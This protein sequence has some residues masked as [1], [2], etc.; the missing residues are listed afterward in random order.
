MAAVREPL[1]HQPEIVDLRRVTGRQLQP[2]LL[3]ETVEWDRT[4][5]W[6]FGRSAELVVQYADSRNLGGVALLD[7]GEVAGY[8]YSVLEDHKGLIG[9]LYI[10]PP[11]RT[12]ENEA[13][14]LR[15]M[16]QALV[17]LH[18]VSRIESQIML[19]D[20]AAARLVERDHPVRLHERIL[21]TL[22]L[23]APSEPPPAPAH[24]RLEP[25][26]DLHHQYA[27]AIIASSYKDH[28]DSL[29]NDQYRSHAGAQRFLYNIVQYPGCGNFCRAAS[30]LAFDRSTGS[31]AGVVLSSLVGR[32]TGHI[33]QLCIA[34]SAQGQG[35][36]RALLERAIAGLRG[37]GL[38]R[39]TLTVT[40][41]NTAAL[42]LYEQCG[43]REIR[44]F[45][46]CIWDR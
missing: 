25:W 42:R 23:G 11:W 33:T 22:P 32:Q 41:A 1:T 46:A 19:L 7:R 37:R 14:L 38:Q 4:L 30:H 35:L 13:L 36:G 29:I 3:E 2:L 34:P 6:D 10:R 39:V 21:M 26:G 16:L 24:F 28:V 12:P 27:S 40:A 43:F 17:G 5:D 20:P 31:P 9:D 45:V 44:R 8:G 15:L 18:Q